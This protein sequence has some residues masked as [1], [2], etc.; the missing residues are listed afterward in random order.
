MTDSEKI[1]LQMLLDVEYYGE[2]M[3]EVC[4]ADPQEIP[5]FRSLLLEVIESKQAIESK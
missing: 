5:A 3:R 4:L 2:R 1:A